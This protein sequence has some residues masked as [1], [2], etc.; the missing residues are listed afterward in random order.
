[1]Q[2]RGSF[3]ECGQ[4]AAAFASFAQSSAAAPRARGD[5]ESRDNERTITLT[6]APALTKFPVWIV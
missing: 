3:Q 5:A 2:A 1:M 4:S 6:G